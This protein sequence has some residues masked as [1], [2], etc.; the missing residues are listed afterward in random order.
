VTFR[1]PEPVDAEAERLAAEIARVLV[2]A[3]QL[4]VEIPRFGM[5]LLNVSAGRRR[6]ELFVGLEAPFATLVLK[7]A[8][9][10]AKGLVDVEIIE[11]N[12]AASRFRRGL[13]TVAQRIAT[14]TT[15]AQW[16]EALEHAAKLARLPVGVPMEF[17]R[18]AIA[19]L[20]ELEGLVRVGFRCNQDCPMCWQGREWGNF[21]GEQVRT[22][23]EDL[24]SAGATRLIISGGEPT[25]DRRL[26]EY[27]A[28][29]RGL[30][31]TQVII[32][33]NVIKCAKP[34]YAETLR[35][36][37]LSAAFVSLH[38]GD[39]E[40]SDRITRAP[41]T[42][43]RT[44]AGI[45]ALL[46]AGVPVKLN[47]VMTQL[48]LEHLAEL[49]DFINESFGH[50]REN[51][52]GVMFS[53]PTEPFERG[54]MREILPDPIRLREVLRE[55]IDR[56]IALDL[57]PHGLDGPCGP[58]LCAFDA[59]PRITSLTPIPGPLDFRIHIEACE[60][61]SVKSACFG[62]RREDFALHGDAAVSPIR[63]E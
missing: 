48:G 30:G 55:T 60:T 58:A 21:D 19:G 23:I 40:V 61:C 16:N 11:T 13:E 14:A 34:D 39:A 59:D 1:D 46:E 26:P 6:I 38:S 44:V 57:Q 24:A 8:R 33:S 54:L 5:N 52:Q 29:A 37:G 51:L 18:Q 2:R 35:E 3:P 36:A 15:E 4:P 56:A 25:L 27:I 47:A 49:P 41:G 32:E 53:Y 7:A 42:H 22:W 9:S 43:A 28:H 17:H 50:V 62:I 45:T 63:S 10:D 20:H 12:Q 31:Y